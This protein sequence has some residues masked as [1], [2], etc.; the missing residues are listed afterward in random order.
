MT[1]FEIEVGKWSGEWAKHC[2]KSILWQKYFLQSYIVIA[3]N[4]I[5]SSDQTTWILITICWGGKM[6]Q[7]TSPCVKS[8]WRQKDGMGLIS[9]L[10]FW[11]SCNCVPPTPSN[12][13]FSIHININITFYN[14]LS[15]GFVILSSVV[16][17]FILPSISADCPDMTFGQQTSWVINYITGHI[18]SFYS[19]NPFAW[20]SLNFLNFQNLYSFA[21]IIEYC[22]SLVSFCQNLMKHATSR[23]NVHLS[24]IHD[25]QAGNSRIDWINKPPM[26][27][28]H[29]Q[30][31][32][33]IWNCN[34][35]T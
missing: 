5:S 18:L 19:T 7:I 6:I 3:P 14:S 28:I 13:R 35:N 10:T 22:Q 8:I 23:S 31:T 2:E 27:V 9:S 33:K 16:S 11:W 34:S 21:M 29:Q 17:V 12:I 24:M 20:K 32:M 4:L 15:D 1:K 25:Q 26:C 30:I